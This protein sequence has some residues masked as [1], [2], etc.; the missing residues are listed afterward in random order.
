MS[1]P[2]P[3]PA[4]PP[5]DE[6]RDPRGD[7]PD[8]AARSGRRAELAANLSAVEDRVAGACAAAGRRREEV[9]LIVVT[10]TWPAADVRLLHE[11]GVR[12]V[13]ESRDQE[14][15]DKAAQL[16]DLPLRWHFVGQLQR[17]KA[18]SVAGY[19]ALVHTV[20][21]PALVTAL[22]SAA[23]TLPP[24]R[25]PLPVLVQVS[26]DRLD[27]LDD[28]GEPAAAGRGG[29]APAAVPELAD[30]VAAAGPLQLRGVMAVAPL[31]VDPAPCFARLAAVSAQLVAGHPDA[32]VVSAGM[33]GDL[34]AAVAA[35]AT[36]LRVGTA[37]L[38]SRPPVR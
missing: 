6:R 12:D 34:E 17:N 14:G 23:G 31:G 18:R 3:S 13:A 20:D 28:A 32:T 24:S 33:S 22:A 37:V 21:R 16:Q 15:R 9:T 4:G 10:K 8:R 11:L 5:G 35:G 38:G 26:L 36:H 27:G 1:A 2:E 25:Q 29:A 7:H 30:L 19:A